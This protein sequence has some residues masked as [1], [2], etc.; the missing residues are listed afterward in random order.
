MCVE[1]L[2][3][4]SEADAMAE[5]CEAIPFPGPWWQG[6]RAGDEGEL[7]HQQTVGDAPP[8]WMIEPKRMKPMNHLDRSARDAFRQLWMQINSADSWNANPWVW[9]VE[10]KQLKG[11]KA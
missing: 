6:Y 9:V 5:G 11:A 10:F 8:E 2:Q 4:I 7:H 1:R 3:D